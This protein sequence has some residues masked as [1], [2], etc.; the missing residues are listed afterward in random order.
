MRT[1]RCYRSVK[2][3][4]HSCYPNRMKR[5]FSYFYGRKPT[6]LQTDPNHEKMPAPADLLHPLRR[7]FRPSGAGNRQMRRKT[8]VRSGRNR[9]LHVYRER[10]T[11][12]IHARCRRRRA[13]HQPRDPSR[14]PGPP[15]G[16]RP[17]F[18]RP[19]DPAAKRYDFELLPWPGSEAC[20][21]LLAV[22]D[23][24]PKTETHF[25]RLRTEIIPVLQT[26]TAAKK[27]R[28]V[29]QATI[30]LGDIVWDSPQLFAGV[31]AEF[32]SLASPYTA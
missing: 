8:G 6:K 20:Y 19:Y 26:E 25:E 18:Y 28:G 2:L 29:A 10:C 1:N 30:L 32:A 23:P 7:S 4:I 27:A 17:Q 5:L 24:Q 15:D 16:G 14:I 11:G 22:A 3:P 12:L 13:V 9:R 31:K 21:E